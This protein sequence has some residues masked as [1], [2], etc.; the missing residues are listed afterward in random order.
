MYVYIY[1]YIYICIER[2]RD[3]GLLSAGEKQLL[4]LARAL[5]MTQSGASVLLMDEAMIMSM[6]L[7][8]KTTIKHIYYYYYHYCYYCYY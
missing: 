1:I 5:L 2:E 7:I 8:M 3:V 6:M 4:C